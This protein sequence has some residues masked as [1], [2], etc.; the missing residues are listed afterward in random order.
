[1]IEERLYEFATSMSDFG[2]C[3]LNIC[4][5]VV[6]ITEL[7]ENGEMGGVHTFVHPEIAIQSLCRNEHFDANKI[8][9]ICYIGK[10][11]Y[12]AFFE[13]T[14]PEIYKLYKFT[15]DNDGIITSIKSSHMP[16]RKSFIDLIFDKAQKENMTLEQLE[17]EL[18]IKFK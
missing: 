12:S 6:M 3:K 10:G 2:I 17:K 11:S 18:N 16:I 5:F 4:N 1:M 9:C 8:L 14:V 13:Y 7:H 15:A